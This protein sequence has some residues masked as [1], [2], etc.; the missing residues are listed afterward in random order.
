[1]DIRARTPVDQLVH[2]IQDHLNR[3]LRSHDAEIDKGETRAVKGGR[4]GQMGRM[5]RVSGPLRTTVTSDEPRPPRSMA[6]DL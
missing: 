6:I 2:Y 5:T 4:S 1:V 3:V